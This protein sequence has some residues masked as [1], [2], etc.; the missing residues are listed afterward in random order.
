MAQKGKKGT[1]PPKKFRVSESAGKLIATVFWDCEGI[2]LIDYK[3]K[4]R[5]HQGKTSRK[6]DQRYVAFARQR[7]GS[8]EQ[9]CNGCSAHTWLRIASP[10]NLQSRSCPK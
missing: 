9:S 4:G 5:V 1:P 10:P 2:L 3:D 7:T 8:Q 6:T